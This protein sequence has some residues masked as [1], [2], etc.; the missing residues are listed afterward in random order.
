[1]PAIVL[2]VVFKDGKRYLLF[3][4]N[5]QSITSLGKRM[6]A[7]RDTMLKVVM[8]FFADRRQM[9]RLIHRLDDRWIFSYSE[10]IRYIKKN[11]CFSKIANVKHPESKARTKASMKKETK[12]Q[13]LKIS[14][15]TPSFFL[16]KTKYILLI[17]TMCIVLALFSRLIK[18]SEVEQIAFSYVS[19]NS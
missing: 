4:T 1:M 16:R 12:N 19:R 14:D 10:Q 7:G 3:I 2:N 18:C 6:K 13:M 11:I 9:V 8:R 17:N 5:K 15:K